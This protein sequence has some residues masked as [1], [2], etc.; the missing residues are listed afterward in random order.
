MAP[1]APT[2]GGPALRRGVSADI[3]A[4]ESQVQDETTQLLGR[5][6]SL[7]DKVQAIAQNKPIGGVKGALVGALSSTPGRIIMKPLEI[8]DAGRR[9]VISGARELVDALDSDPNTKASLQDF[10]KQVSDP[11]YGFGKAFPVKGKAGYITGFLGDVLLDP[12]TYATLGTAGV[13]GAGARAAV[14]A[15]YLDRFGDAAKA[16]QIAQR[17]K[18]VL[19]AAEMAELGLKRSGVYFFGEKLRVPL[20]GPIGE[21]M[22][23]GV[24]KT[25]LGFTNTRLGK[26]LQRGFMGMGSNG[27]T[28]LRDI[29]LA[30][31]R[32]EQLPNNISAEAGIRLVN[33]ENIRRSISNEAVQL[34][35]R[36]MAEELEGVGEDQINTYGKV[37]YKWLEGSAIPQNPTEQAFADRFKSLFQELWDNVN[38]DFKQLVPDDDLAKITEYFPWVMTREARDITTDLQTDWV[39]GLMSFL[40]PNP[41]DR[42]GS[43]KSRNLKAGDGFLWTIDDAGKK[44]DY[45]LKPEDLNIERLNEISR[46]ALGVDFFETD[47]R[48]VLQDYSTSFARQK[49]LLAMYKELQDKGIIQSLTERNVV[50]EEMAAAFVESVNSTIRSSMATLDSA[51]VTLKEAVSTISKDARER[52]A[53]LPKATAAA[54]EALTTA[55]AGAIPV[56]EAVAINRVNVAKETISAL[57]DEIGGLQQRLGALFAGGVPDELTPVIDNYER[58]KIA[59]KEVE[60]TISAKEA[61]IEQLTVARNS[62]LLEGELAGLDEAAKVAEEKLRDVSRRHQL[63]M[64]LNDIVGDRYDDIVSGVTPRDADLGRT[65]GIIQG[66][67]RLVKRPDAPLSI[68]GFADN[69]EPFQ[70]WAQS[71]QTRLGN[72]EWFKVVANYVSPQRFN[73]RGVS[74]VTYDEAIDIAI[75][76]TPTFDNAYDLL[77][78]G[79]FLLARDLKFHGSGGNDSLSAVRQKLVDSMDK[80][81]KA[82]AIRD[83]EGVSTEAIRELKN[84]RSSYEKLYGFIQER[85]YQREVLQKAL[86]DTL[87]SNE[88]PGWA[89]ASSRGG[90]LFSPDDFAASDVLDNIGIDPF[91]SPQEFVAK[92]KFF[93]EGTNSPVGTGP[94][95]RGKDGAMTNAYFWDDLDFVAKKYDEASSRYERALNSKI[96]LPD[97]I[98]NDPKQMA[99]LQRGF[100][101]SLRDLGDNVLA[102]ALTS[103]VERRF[104]ALG[105]EFATYGLVPTKDM[106]ATIVRVVGEEFYQQSA[107][108]AA[109]VSRT[110]DALS[111]LREKVM[112]VMAQKGNWIDE[113]NKGIA[114]IYAG[115]YGDDILQVLGPDGAI[116]PAIRQARA[117]RETVASAA[118]EPYYEAAKDLMSEPIIAAA[119][120]DMGMTPD[121]L[122]K[123]G[124]RVAYRSFMRKI[125][126]QIDNGTFDFGPDLADSTL[127]RILG[128]VAT[129]NELGRSAKDATE[130]FDDVLREWFAKNFPGR[131][132]SLKALDSALKESP[133]SSARAMK[134]WFT[135]HLGGYYRHGASTQGSSVGTRFSTRGGKNAALTKQHGEGEFVAELIQGS[136][137]NEQ[138][139]LDARMTALN[140]ITD[141]SA[142][143]SDFLNDPFGVDG[144]PLSYERSLRYIADRIK[145]DLQTV[146]PRAVRNVEKALG[147]YRTAAARRRYLEQFIDERLAIQEEDVTQ[148]L[149]L[150]TFNTVGET[151]ARRTGETAQEY[152]QRIINALADNQPNGLTYLLTDKGFRKVLEINELVTE[153]SAIRKVRTEIAKILKSEEY[154][155]AKHDEDFYDFMRTIAGFDGWRM[156]NGK[157]GESGWFIDDT[158]VPDLNKARSAR[159]AVFI[160]PENQQRRAQILQRLA[161]DR[162]ITSEVF[163]DLM[164]AG[165]AMRPVDSLPTA[166]KERIGPN[167]MAG[168]RD[169]EDVLT[170]SKQEWTALFE[171]PSA[172]QMA[173]TANR[174]GLI[175]REIA[176]LN[177]AL[178]DGRTFTTVNGVRIKISNRILQLNEESAA[179]AFI[180]ESG[181]AEVLDIA[182]RKARSLFQQ[183]NETAPLTLKK[184]KAK[185]HFNKVKNYSGADGF[186][187]SASVVR[188]R[189][190]NLQSGWE[191][192]GSAKVIRRLKGLQNSEEIKRF[193]EAVGALRN[194]RSAANDADEVLRTALE[195]IGEATE[196]IAGLLDRTIREI[197]ISLSRGGSAFS[198]EGLQLIDAVKNHVQELLAGSPEL[199]LRLD[200]ASLR[201]TLPKEIRDA[202]EVIGKTY[203]SPVERDFAQAISG[204][205]PNQELANAAWDLARLKGARSYLIQ[206]QKSMDDEIIALTSEIN[207]RALK[208]IP[209]TSTTKN[210]ALP[211]GYVWIRQ[212][213]TTTYKRVPV[214]TLFDDA[215]KA[216]NKAIG[217]WHKMTK[218]EIAAVNKTLGLKSGELADAVVELDYAQSALD[219][220]LPNL[221]DAENTVTYLKTFMEPRVLKLEE[222]LKSIPKMPKGKKNIFATPEAYRDLLDVI[223][224]FR[225]VYNDLLKDPDDPVFKAL[226]DVANV[227][228][229]YM[230]VISGNALYQAEASRLVGR[231]S[232]NRVEKLLNEGFAALEIAVAGNPKL[233]WA[234]APK[235]VV[236]FFNNTRRLKD[237]E[238]QRGVLR[239]MQRYTRFFKS[240]ATLSPGFHVRNA[241]S[242]TFA[243]VAAGGDVRN[244][245]KGLRLY[246]SFRD[247]MN[248]KLSV[249]DWVKTLPEADREAANIAARSMYA[250]GGGQVSEAF[251]GVA[252]RAPGIKGKIQENAVLR[253]SRNVGGN[254]ESSARFMLGYDSALKGMDF[255][256]ASARVR[257]YMVDYEDVGTFD[258]KLR[259][260][261][262]FWMWTSRALPMHLA[263]QWLNPRPYAI[264]ESFKRNIGQDDEGDIVPS[265]IT[266]QGGI[267]IGDN[268]YLM[269]D[270]GFNRLGQQVAELGDPMRLMSQANPLLRLPVELMGGRK[271]YTGQEFQDKPVEVSG[272]VSALLQPLLQIAGYGETTPEGKRFVDEKALYALQ[273]L[274]PF[275]A[276]GERLLPSTEG[277]LEKQAQSLRGYFG[278][279]I[280]EVTETQQRGEL[281]RQLRALQDLGSRQEAMYGG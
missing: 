187:T 206:N 161:D 138:S 209:S 120:K 174:Q 195:P 205:N 196:S 101:Q 255:N 271:L 85:I 76:A 256:T 168:L 108:R 141:P 127:E 257:R 210:V 6:P 183:M 274:V 224:D 147:Q 121:W 261:I 223:E 16:A 65:V 79:A 264:Y 73:V 3:R 135:E 110:I 4:V 91:S 40:E 68:E 105:K 211:P 117:R 88:V 10:R 59:L 222:L 238:F 241:M 77:N 247:A 230:G 142:N 240:Y 62:G 21:A 51:A 2:G 158:L 53:A 36:R 119:A 221:I 229:Q 55:I 99:D 207:G 9:G 175:K 80:A 31:A 75:A 225:V 72:E 7:Q 145:S 188:S 56:A 122:S 144:G 71:L 1:I 115:D 41:L 106:Y 273:N 111:A 14:A 33:A 165:G 67:T 98:K 227:H 160:S 47:L 280:R 130:E 63:F 125:I 263:N 194:V 260:I 113:F 38:E 43:F 81:S 164:F 107:S 151:V 148:I 246:M 262:P 90:P 137:R 267:K 208:K 153:T 254:L 100:E 149:G 275:L 186:A 202:A 83:G 162:I 181:R 191:S 173:R 185:T 279:P 252:R 69:P 94:V 35:Q 30:L 42:T 128:K 87:A 176:S 93:L 49:G 250:S 259:V 152:R 249:D 213:G 109:S 27:S 104:T 201:T 46:G 216:M 96:Q 134:V 20:S 269:P 89:F 143:V 265:W 103:E 180:L 24:T 244:F 25:R 232:F 197:E 57:R 92:V 219:N 172:Q 193:N 268:S 15:K 140:N 26:T 64:S 8:L 52:V 178:K 11:T 190:A 258:E 84:V 251:V 253:T 146:S 102:Y 200:I 154:I 86:D 23:S 235:E 243:L 272:G 22:L 266:E 112:T 66:K 139:I 78:A 177:Q 44:V 132:F 74:R 166:L 277:G 126:G 218:Q 150:S 248:N 215:A 118:R 179:N 82:I 199:G 19:D 163:R 29:R 17:G 58:M 18:T 220:I 114:D 156:V 237:P 203:T 217:E 70:R 167:I 192:S 270:L 204:I 95:R 278:I 159:R 60:D 5:F 226:A 228:A 214:K 234:Q 157:T 189:R 133:T 170:F 236:D 12:L 136:L 116:A 245:P 184:S 169:T 182:T 281:L 129:V 34:A 233:Q 54:D 198:P 212:E 48:V 32:G 155:M 276:Q 131:K 123:H 97:S 61:R 124:E 50:D 37:A 28:A 39:K 171:R 231:A 13:V 45:I 242:N 239:F